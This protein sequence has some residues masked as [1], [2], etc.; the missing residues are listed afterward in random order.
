MQKGNARIVKCPF[1]GEEKELL[2]LISGNGMGSTSWSDGKTVGPMMPRVSPVQKC[3]RC[4]KYY[5][6][7]KQEGRTGDSMSDERGRLSYSQW[8]EA[9][10][11]FK[12]D[13]TI[14]DRDRCIILMNL[15]HGYNDAYYRFYDESGTFIQEPPFEPNPPK[16]E[17]EFFVSNV[18][19]YIALADL[20][21]PE[22]LMFKAELYREAGM[23]EECKETLE[24][25]DCAKLHPYTRKIYDGIKRRMEKKV[26]K[27]F[28]ISEE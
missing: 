13:A 15:I 20:T 19:R 4:G 23:F 22:D 1:C 25:V 6:H 12:E 5:L 10:E 21:R 18:Q 17:F 2:S 27:V 9:Y 7:Y 3:P 28:R 8:K 16:E 26:K 11:Q 24:T 14:D